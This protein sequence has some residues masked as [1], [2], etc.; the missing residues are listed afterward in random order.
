MPTDSSTGGYI[1]PAGTPPLEDDALDDFMQALVV[2]ITGLPGAS[3]RPRFQQEPPNI[4]A[5]GTDWA[6]IGITHRRADTFAVE[7]HDSTGQG[8]DTLIR[9]E[10]LDLLCSFYGPAAQSNG[11]RLRDGISIAQNR[12]ALQLA[13]M[14]LISV[15]DLTKAPEMIKNRWL[16]RADLMVAIRREVRR[17]YPVLNLLSLTGAL[18]SKTVTDALASP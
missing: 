8:T 7:Q 9:H 3:V 1:A 11:A 4:P 16:N 2:G 18:K 10:E 14:G 5:A 17:S 6:A 13:G 15:G 12:E